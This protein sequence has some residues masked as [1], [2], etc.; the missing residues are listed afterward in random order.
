LFPYVLRGF[1]YGIVVFIT[2]RIHLLLAHNFRNPS[3]QVQLSALVLATLSVVSPLLSSGSGHPVHF[4]FPA[5]VTR[6]AIMGLVLIVQSCSKDGWNSETPKR[7]EQE[8]M[9]RL[10][11]VTLV[12][13]KWTRSTSEFFAVSPV[14]PVA[15]A[16]ARA[17]A[18]AKDTGQ[19]C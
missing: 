1:K 9:T 3:L 18:T 11:C 7:N 13:S 2:H 5:S 16:K 14:S 12:T 4:S 15:R 19:R 6:E 17:K 8:D 10:T